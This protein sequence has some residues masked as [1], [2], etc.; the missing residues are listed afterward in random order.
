[1]VVLLLLILWRNRFLCGVAK[2]QQFCYVLALRA[3]FLGWFLQ[4]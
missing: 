3:F 2:L 1:V 4:L